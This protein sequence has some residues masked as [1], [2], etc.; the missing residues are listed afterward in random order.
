VLVI[1]VLN[2]LFS[3]HMQK[4]TMGDERRG[5]VIFVKPI[6]RRKDFR[7]LGKIQLGF[8]RG[9]GNH[10]IYLV[11]IKILYP[12]ILYNSIFLICYVL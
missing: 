11:Q 2:N 5:V 12:S 8:H 3:I 7:M 10:N 9:R 1:F 4:E 6:E